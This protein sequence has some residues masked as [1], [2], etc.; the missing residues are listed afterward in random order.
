M[1]KLSITYVR[2]IWLFFK[3]NYTKASSNST[4]KRGR[5][6]IISWLR[7]RMQDGKALETQSQLLMKS[8]PF[9]NLTDFRFR[10][11]WVNPSKRRKVYIQK[12]ILAGFK[13]NAKSDPADQYLLQEWK[14]ARLL[15]GTFTCAKLFKRRDRI[16]LR[17]KYEKFGVP[18]QAPSSK[19]SKCAVPK[20]V[21]EMIISLPHQWCWIKCQN[22][23]K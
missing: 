2:D 3:T 17:P 1:D 19:I 9:L 18:T 12:I 4:L 16:R 8:T 14:G 23:W 13:V 5:P 10:K 22:S 7:H 11:R 6:S 20:A 21:E 15:K